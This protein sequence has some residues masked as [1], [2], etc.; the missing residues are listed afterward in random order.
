MSLQDRERFVSKFSCAAR[1]LSKY[2][3]S[4]TKCYQ[5]R[6]ETKG[7]ATEGDMNSANTTNVRMDGGKKNRKGKKHQKGNKEM[8]P[9]LTPRLSMQV[10]KK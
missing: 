1:S 4:V 9:E 5:S 10:T 8:L 2:S 7:M 6:F 3:K